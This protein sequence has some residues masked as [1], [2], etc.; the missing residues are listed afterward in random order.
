MN[1][2]YIDAELMAQVD[3]GGI[4]GELVGLCP[5]GELIA[6]AAAFV[7][8]VAAHRDVY[9]KRSPMLGLGLVQRAVAVPLIAPM[10][11][12]LEP[13]QVE[14]LR[15]RDLGSEPVEVNTWHGLISHVKREETVPF[16]LSI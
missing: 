8:I 5:E 4:Q 14:Y 10:M 2:G 3:R 13:Q 1:Q 7:A 12:G 9:G 11:N 15:H 16:P 6:P